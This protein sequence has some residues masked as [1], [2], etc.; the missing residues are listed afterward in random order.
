MKVLVDTNFFLLPNQFGVDIFSFLKFHEI[1]TLSCCVNELKQ[2]AK[3]KTK[4]GTAAKIGLKLIDQNHV[5][6]ISVKDK[7]ADSAILNYSL[8]EKCAV[9]TNDKAL[10]KALKKQDIKI[11]RLRQN[12]YLVEE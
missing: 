1:F 7:K 8:Q 3:K 12:K 6:I 11:I 2:I 5:V 4:D 9:A 10:I